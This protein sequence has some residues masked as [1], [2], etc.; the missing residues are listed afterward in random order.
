MPSPFLST[1]D[2]VK[3]YGTRRVLDGVSLT[4]YAERCLGL[5]GKD[6]RWALSCKIGIP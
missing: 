5:V 6:G 2:L 4:V 3:T 1:R